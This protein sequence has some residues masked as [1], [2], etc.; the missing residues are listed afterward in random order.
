MSSVVAKIAKAFHREIWSMGLFRLADV[1]LRRR[2]PVSSNQIH[3]AHEHRE[4]DHRS[5][6]ARNAEHKS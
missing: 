5:F 3:H 4:K 6:P 2:C 1:S